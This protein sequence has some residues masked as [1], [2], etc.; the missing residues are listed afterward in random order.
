PK[1]RATALSI[2]SFGIPLGTMFGAALGGFLAEKFGWRVAFMS[3]GL[4]GLILAAI[5]W[6][7]V[8]EPPRGHADVPEHPVLPEDVVPEP[9]KPP[10]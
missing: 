8:K 9:T 10:F 3:V 2:Y 1:K 5:V 7:V 6:L 4:P